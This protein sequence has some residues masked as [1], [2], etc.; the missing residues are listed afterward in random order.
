MTILRSQGLVAELAAEQL[1]PAA[2]GKGRNIWLC[3]GLVQALGDAD[4]VALHDCDVV[5]FT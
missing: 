1:A 5:T 3:L 4:V 2:A